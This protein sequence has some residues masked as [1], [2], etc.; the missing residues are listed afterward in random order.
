MDNFQGRVGN[1]RGHYC[2]IE[3][4]IVKLIILIINLKT[5]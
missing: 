1:V 4:F 5:F 3:C 2:E